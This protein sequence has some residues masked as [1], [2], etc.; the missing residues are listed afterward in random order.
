M[1]NYRS[2]D[3]DMASVKVENISRLLA[4]VAE[5]GRNIRDSR[6]ENFNV[7]AACFFQAYVCV[8]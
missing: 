3:I 1:E 8:C 4:C 5:L 2:A 6:Q 7:Q